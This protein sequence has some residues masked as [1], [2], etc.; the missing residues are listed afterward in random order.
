MTNSKNSAEILGKISKTSIL[1]LIFVLPL[2]FLPGTVNILD[3]NKQM[4]LV[5]LVFL[6]LF[7]YLLKSLIE[8]EITLNISRFNLV[9]IFFIFVLGLATLFSAA[10]YGSFWGWPLNIASSFLTSLALVLFYFLVLHQ[11]EAQRLLFPLVA[12][13]LLAGLFGLLQIFEKFLLPFDFTKFSSFNTIGTVNSLGFFLAGLIP[14]SLGLFFTSSMKINKV[15]NLIFIVISLVFLLIINFWVAWICLLIGSSLVLA[16]AITRKILNLQYLLLPMVFLVISLFSL[17]I[18]TPLFQ[19]GAVPAEVSPLLST[20]L[21]I[22]IKTIKNYQPPLSLFFG[23]G[24]STFAFDYSKYKPLGVNQTA[25][26]ETRFYTGSSE[27]LDRLATTGI[28]GL[29]SFVIIFAVAGFLGVKTLIAKE[30]NKEDVGNCILLEGVLASF[31]SVVVGFF[32]YSANLSV[33]FL[34]WLLL[35]TLLSLVNGKTKAFKLRPLAPLEGNKKSTTKLILWPRLGISFIFITVVIL[36]LGILFFEGQRYFA[37]RNY[38]L[39]LKNIQAGESLRAIDRLGTAIRLTGG[40]QDNYWRDLAQVYLFR[41]N[42][43]LQKKDVSQPE[44]VKTVNNLVAQAINNTQAATSASPKNVA[45]WTIR[46]LVN[47]NL[48]TFIPEA[49]AAEAI[50]AYEEAINLEPL[51]PSLFT[52]LGKVYL[53]RADLLAQNK[54]KMEKAREALNSARE[55]FQKALNLKSDYAPAYF[56][57]AMIDIRE[58]KTKEAIGKLEM[59]KILAP[60][61]AR[62]ALQ[63]ALIYQSDNQM[64]K[65]KA[66]LERAVALDKNYSNARYF[67]GL[68]YDKEEN[69]EKAIEQFTKIAELNPDNEEVKKI[70]T[71][72][73]EGKSALE[74]IAVNQA[75]IEE[76]PGEKLEELKP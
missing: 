46:G 39:S 38:L 45:N 60:S 32:L 52:E 57:L 27:I 67:L 75:P 71:N 2:F 74:G 18:K 17:G 28:L 58:Q 15:L 26:W 19:V 16:F 70:L 42:E 72:L 5:L 21:E 37:E 24:P 7:C 9:V 36:S 40:A 25:F 8:E 12:A 48:L 34:F 66:E 29:F 1:L 51:N 22:A 55:N 3:F 11:G 76:K 41:I 62:L 63:L 13:G 73:R 53:S 69:K 65:A 64:D 50:K 47:S 59:A 68:I 23:S 54:E 20:N 10:K 43:E 30:V 4:I 14:L 31:F 49:G 33:A 6:S 56:Q 44:L 61:D 35:A